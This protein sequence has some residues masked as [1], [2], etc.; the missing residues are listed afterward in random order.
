MKWVSLS[1]WSHRKIENHHSADSYE[2][3]EELCEE[4]WKQFWNGLCG[5][6]R[7]WPCWT[8]ERENTKV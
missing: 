5:I 1:R 6:G 4:V 2:P 8:R 3:R 7:R